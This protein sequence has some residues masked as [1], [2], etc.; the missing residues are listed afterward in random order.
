M[1]KKE[2]IIQLWQKK[3]NLMVFGTPK[4]FCDTIFTLQMRTDSL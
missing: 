4:G 1:T 2:I 3:E